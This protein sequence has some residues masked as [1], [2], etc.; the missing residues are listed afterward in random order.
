[1]I[2]NDEK[3]NPHTPFG[4]TEST[5]VS[6]WLKQIKDKK[7]QGGW[8]GVYQMTAADVARKFHVPLDEVLSAARG[9]QR[10]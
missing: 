9:E 7:V 10:R 6:D 1:M 8:L 2:M 3:V 4:R 5:W